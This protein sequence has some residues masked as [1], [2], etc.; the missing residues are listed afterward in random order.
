M[1]ASRFFWIQSSIK[2]C[3][4]D[5]DALPRN[6]N[7]EHFCLKAAK[8]SDLEVQLKNGRYKMA[9]TEEKLKV[10]EKNEVQDSCRRVSTERFQ[11]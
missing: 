7:A 4:Y 9:E 1:R 3:L 10:P 5:E 8:K 6:F 11:L 2:F